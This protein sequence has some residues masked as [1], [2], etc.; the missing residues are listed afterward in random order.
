MVYQTMTHIGIIIKGV[1]RWQMHKW[2]IFHWAE[3]IAS[4]HNEII[5]VLTHQT[6]TRNWIARRFWQAE[7]AV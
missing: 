5:Y 3:F 6:V 2:T 7:R 1:L 4:K